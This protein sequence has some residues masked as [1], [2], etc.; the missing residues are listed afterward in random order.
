MAKGAGEGARL[1]PMPRSLPSM[2]S[3]HESV[4]A[5]SSLS[6]LTPQGNSFEVN[7]ALVLGDFFLFLKNL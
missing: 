7:A 1:D 6:T 2:K 4:A 5:V 3:E